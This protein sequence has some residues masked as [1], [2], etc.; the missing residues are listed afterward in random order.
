VA[1][2][3]SP[4]NCISFRLNTTSAIKPNEKAEIE[5]IYEPNKL[6]IKEEDVQLYTN[7]RKN[8]IVTLKLIGEVVSNLSK[9]SPL[10]EQPKGF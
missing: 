5:I 2:A 8:P 6:N 3:Y 4:C 9:Q 1:A 7:S 10:K